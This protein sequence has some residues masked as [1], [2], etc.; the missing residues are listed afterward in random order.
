MTDQNP[1]TSNGR[2]GLR[3]PLGGLL[4]LNGVLLG[5]LALVT[6]GADADAQTR[7]R[8]GDYTMVAGGANGT[9]GSAAVYIVDTVNQEL[10]AIAYNQ[11]DNT[12]DGIAYRNLASDAAGLLRGGG[13]R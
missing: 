5:A 8:R 12:L 9:A 2:F 10:V 7:G 3:G 6:F 1:S 11:Q 13:G 4:L